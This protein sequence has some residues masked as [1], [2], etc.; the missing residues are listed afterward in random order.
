ME[1]FNHQHNKYRGIKGFV[2]LYNDAI[3]YRYMITEPA[4]KKAKIL[5]FW[6]KHGLETTLEAF[7]VKRR[8]LFNWKRKWN[9]GD[10]KPEALNEKSKAPRTKR[11]R[12][13][14]EEVLAEIKRQRFDHPNLGK[15]K[16][17]PILARFCQEK[18]LE[19]P[20]PKTIGRLIKDLGG[21]RRYPGKIS[22][23]G[24]IKIL[25]RKKVLRKPLDFQAEYPGHWCWGRRAASQ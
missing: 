24:K 22:H 19:C 1:Y 3:R 25:N 13:W 6:E 14:P 20:K 17:Y 5:A 4:L 18:G 10:K 21:L 7:E 11:K 15:E 23:F 2:G 16:L 8:T 12:L 9:Q